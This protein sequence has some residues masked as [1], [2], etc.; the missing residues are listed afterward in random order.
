MS[1]NVEEKKTQLEAIE[2]FLK[3][4][5][6]LFTDL[7]SNQ[8]QQNFSI[9]HLQAKFMLLAKIDRF[10]KEDLCQKSE[11]IIKRIKP[12]CDAAL[13]NFSNGLSSVVRDAKQ[14]MTQTKSSSGFDLTK[15]LIL[16]DS[17]FKAFLASYKPIFSTYTS[18]ECEK[19]SA[20]YLV[21]K[22]IV[23]FSLP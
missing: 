11:Q 2:N 13:S 4:W 7:K 15:L 18:V 23:L 22:K 12:L 21:Y 9:D 19:I 16:S 8:K 17:K 6:E 10:L 3:L 14:T 20:L 5:E 1:K